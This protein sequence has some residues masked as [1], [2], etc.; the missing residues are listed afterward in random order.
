MEVLK[1]RTNNILNLWFMD[2]RYSDYWDK[3]LAF[4]FVQHINLVLSINWKP[5]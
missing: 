3:A 5:S 1:I 2:P 4:G